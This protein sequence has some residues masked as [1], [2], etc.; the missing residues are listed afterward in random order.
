MP[1]STQEGSEKSLLFPRGR[2]KPGRIILRKSLIKSLIKSLSK[3]LGMAKYGIEASGT[4][5]G[6]FFVAFF[7]ES[8]EKRI[9]RKE[10]LR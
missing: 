8:V 10:S 3:T 2:N 4:K 7:G 9:V 1:H 6:C 5:T